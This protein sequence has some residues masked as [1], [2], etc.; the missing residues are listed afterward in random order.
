MGA[1]ALDVGN[2]RS[3]VYQKKCVFVAVEIKLKFMRATLLPVNLFVNRVGWLVGVIAKNF[4][5]SSRRR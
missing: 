5:S 1:I 3:L 2:H 4:G